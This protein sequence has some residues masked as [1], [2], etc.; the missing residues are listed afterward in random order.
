MGVATKYN[1]GFIIDYIKNIFLFI[2]FISFFSCAPTVTEKVQKQTKTIEPDDINKE[3][4]EKETKEKVAKKDP[5]KIKPIKPEDKEI[6]FKDIET[7]IVLL[8][9]DELLTTLF[10]DIFLQKIQTYKNLN[11]IKFIHTLDEIDSNIENSLIIG[12]VNSSML[13]T[14]PSKLGSNTFILSLSNDYSLMNKF[15]DNEIIFI[16]NSPYLHVEKLQ[17][18]IN[19]AKTIGLL[20]KQND[21]GLKVFSHFKKNYPLIYNKSSSYGT[22]AIDLELS[23]NLLGNLD[24]ID[25]IIIIDDTPSY[26]DL[27]GYLATEKTIY[28]LE[29][30]YLIDNF[31]E[32]RKILE[33]YYKPIKRTNFANI[34]LSLMNE[35]H[36]EYLFK[37]SV[38]ISLMIADEIFQKKNIPST[39]SHNEF[40]TLQINNQMIDYPIVFD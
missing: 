3:I 1:P 20:Y 35:P 7:I 23:V 40:G 34:D 39:I 29:N 28:P 33:N 16:P 38:E 9:D 27:I 25:Y 8:S 17:R 19:N 5:I 24:E 18:Y 22:S 15:A 37:K 14:L 10:Y 4:I 26:K 36:R 12:P 6:N 21:Y 30:I 11:D 32:Q 31:L 13:S 2:A